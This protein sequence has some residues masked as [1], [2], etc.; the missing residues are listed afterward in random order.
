MSGFFLAAYLAALAGAYRSGDTSI[1]YPPARSLSVIF[2]LSDKR[3][4]A[5][6]AKM[7]YII[8]YGHQL[9]SVLEIGSQTQLRGY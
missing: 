4:K 8:D 2:V 5:A 9:S 3:F 7:D 1:A 6:P